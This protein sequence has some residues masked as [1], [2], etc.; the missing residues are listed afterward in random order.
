MART[1]AVVEEVEAREGAVAEAADAA[2]AAA[3]AR[4]R[5]YL[6]KAKKVRVNLM[7]IIFNQFNRAVQNFL[8]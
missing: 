3:V 5:L 8:I 2:A 1:T 6:E 4:I 7:S